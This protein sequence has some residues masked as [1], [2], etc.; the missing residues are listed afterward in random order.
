MAILVQTFHN[1]LV[2]LHFKTLMKRCQSVTGDCQEEG[3]FACAGC[4][5][6]ELPLSLRA[7]YCGVDCQTVSFP[8]HKKL[9]AMFKKNI[10]DGAGGP[11]DMSGYCQTVCLTFLELKVADKLPVLREDTLTLLFAGARDEVL[12]D[13]KILL[14]LLRHFVYANLKKLK[15]VLVGPSAPSGMLT[16]KNTEELNVTVKCAKVENAFNP[17]TIKAFDAFIMIAPGFSSFLDDWQPAISLFTSTQAPVIS[18]AYS[19][20]DKKDNDA[21]FDEDCMVKY[22]RA[23]LVVP[24]TCNPR[25]EAYPAGPLGHKNRYYFVTQGI[26][27][28]LPVIDRTQFKRQLSAGYLEFQADYYGWRDQGFADACRKMAKGLLDGSY[29][30][31]H[32]T[33]SQLID[34]ARRM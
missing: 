26:E 17:T 16:S 24:T 5:S 9:H 13:F 18:T 33:M 10:S 7:R 3:K 31:R 2:Q 25:C 19:S 14:T 15:V 29:P 6:I 1:D 28:D 27:T 11:R 4:G 22:F 12:I 34:K 20:Y 30:Y 32:E 8:E 21:L 23:K